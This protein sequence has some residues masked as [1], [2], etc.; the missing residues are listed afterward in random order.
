VSESVFHPVFDFTFTFQSW[1]TR[2]WNT[3]TNTHK[4]TP[5]LKTTLDSNTQKH[6]H[7]HQHGFPLPWS[8]EGWESGQC[9]FTHVL[10]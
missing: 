1:L 8:T 7:T 5:N 6:T 4:Y 9:W 2:A 3:R 10:L